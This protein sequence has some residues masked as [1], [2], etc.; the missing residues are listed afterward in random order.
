MKNLYYFLVF[1]RSDY[2]I[3]EL[4]ER[5]DGFFFS[6]GSGLASLLVLLL[7]GD[8]LLGGVLASLPFNF[9]TF[10][11]GDVSGSLQVQ[12]DGEDFVF[13]EVV[14]GEV[15]GDGEVVWGGRVF[16]VFIFDSSQRLQDFLIIFIDVR[17][18]G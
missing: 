7:F 15:H 1:F 6:D 9:G 14:G 12:E 18:Y 11:L 4:E 13:K 5:G 8:H 3:E 2:T 16:R 10:G 17:F